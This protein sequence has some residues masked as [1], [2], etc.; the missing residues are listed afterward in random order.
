MKTATNILAAIIMLG[1]ASAAS[2]N[3]IDYFVE[4]NDQPL[5]NMPHEGSNAF[6]SSDVRTEQ[7]DRAY[8]GRQASKFFTP[9]G[10]VA[11]W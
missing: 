9:D 10:D 8:A 2:A 1:A 6:A 7:G 4:P 5:I 11:A 3:Q